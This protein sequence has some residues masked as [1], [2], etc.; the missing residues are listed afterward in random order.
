MCGPP[1]HADPADPRFWAVLGDVDQVEQAIMHGADI[2]GREEESGDSAL[3]K[4]TLNGHAA[5]V[6][7]LLR[8]EVRSFPP[9]VTQRRLC[10]IALPIQPHYNS[11]SS[12]S[13]AAEVRTVRRPT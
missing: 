12:G 9:P 8:M 6:D 13:P 7:L 10:S 4:A 3:I 1:S 5:V 2:D 11:R